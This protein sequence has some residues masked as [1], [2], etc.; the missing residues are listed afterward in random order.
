MIRAC[1]YGLILSWLNLSLSVMAEEKKVVSLG[2]DITAIIYALKAESA[3]VGVDL[4]SNYPE[5]ASQLA[6]VGYIRQLNT[7]G[8]LS[9][10][11][12]MILAH[13]DAGPPAVIEQLKALGV[14][15]TI[16]P[17]DYSVQ[18][19][20][21]KV[22][23]LGELLDRK[24]EAGL[25]VKRLQQQ[26]SELEE[27]KAKIDYQPRTVF[28]LSTGTNLVVAGKNTAADAAINLFGG[29]N[30]VSQYSG[31]KPMSIEG[32]IKLR[33][34]VLLLMDV[35][36]TVATELASH[37]AIKLSSAREQQAVI[38]VDG[39]K[40]LGFGLYSIEIALELQ[41]KIAEMLLP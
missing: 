4:T 18:G 24:A 32:L 13:H 36:Q 11:P 20:F 34:D 25:L 8:I 12:T 39:A 41:K 2:G 31:Y 15:L 9:L 33:P 26:A 29:K 30:A 27:H 19:I 40:L 5:Q 35:E 3:L 38:P 22:E 17:A 6:N 21:H 28:I 10:K 14:H 7:E 1:L 23:R 16:F 37:P